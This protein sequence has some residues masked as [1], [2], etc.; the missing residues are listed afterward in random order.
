MTI[1]E[2]KPE[3]WR[4]TGY[5]PDS[6][7]K[8]MASLGIGIDYQDADYDRYESEFRADLAEHDR[9][10]SEKAW[11][12]ACWYAASTDTTARIW[13]RNNPHRQGVR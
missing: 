1:H 2:Y 10:V 5:Y 8:H 9:E 6:Y 3:A 13:Q 4:M 7:A 12:A 11:D